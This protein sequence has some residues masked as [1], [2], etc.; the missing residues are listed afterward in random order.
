[1]NI[2]SIDTSTNKVSVALKIDN[3]IDSLENRQEIRASQ[4][5]LTMIDKI[6]NKHKISCKDLNAISFNKGPASFTGTRIA[7]SITQ[8]IGYTWK[9]PVFGVSSLTIMAFDY[10]KK[11]KHS[12]I[13]SIK[14]AYS[15]K[16]FWAV[17][18]I[19]KNSFKPISG[20]HISNF[21]DI[22]LDGD[23]KWYGISDCWDDYES[24]TNGSIDK[25]IEKTD[26]NEKGNAERIID[27]VLSN[28]KIDKEF[29]YK[30]TLPEYVS[31]DLYD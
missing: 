19:G 6:L 1:M 14:K 20:N 16:V 31:H 26:I 3:K 7:S 9:I 25:L 28:G 24:G 18:N 29:D 13:I 2:L 4:I 5:V 15:Q 21:A 22:K 27:F 23:S 8:A 10:F 11:T 17:Y 30:D 12:E